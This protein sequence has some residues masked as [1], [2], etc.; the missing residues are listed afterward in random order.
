MANYKT[1][2][3]IQAAKKARLLWVSHAYELIQAIPL[4]VDHGPYNET[5]CIFGKW[6]YGDEGKQFAHLSTFKDL[7]ASHRRL[8]QIYT[9]AFS[10]I[11]GHSADVG[12]LKFL[13]G[14]PRGV[15]DEQQEA[16]ATHCRDLQAISDQVSAALDALEAEVA[17]C[18]SA[19]DWALNRAAVQG[20]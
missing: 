9:N 13:F 6:I 3:A 14:A 20:I 15:T 1:L 19:R 4:V 5:E 10:T 11:F 8:H 18:T 2:C 7:E 12:L 16:A 17:A